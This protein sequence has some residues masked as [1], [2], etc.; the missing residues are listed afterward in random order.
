M[1]STLGFAVASSGKVFG[2][3]LAN[4]WV[5]GA[6]ASAFC[7]FGI[8]LFGAFDF[9]M[10]S[11]LQNKLATLG[12]KRSGVQKVFLMGLV[13]GIIAAPCTGPTLGAILTYVAA[14][15]NQ[16]FGILM[17]M[18]F[19]LGLGLPFL[20]LGTFAGLVAARPKPGPWMESVK[21]V[22]G[23]IMFDMALYF[24]RSVF[25][26][27]NGL[28]GSSPLYFIAGAACIAG[29]IAI[30][31]LNISFHRASTLRISRKIAGIVLMIGGSF[32]IAG[33]AFFGS[34]H[35]SANS[36]AARAGMHW[37]TDLDKGLSLAR[38]QKK[39]AIIDFYADWC[40]ACKE[41]DKTVFSN[42]EV[43]A[44]LSRFVCIREDLTIENAATKKI[45]L[46][47]TLRGIPVIE[48]YASSGERLA[49]NRIAGFVPADKLLTML[50]K[51]P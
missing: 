50:K 44:E 31:G 48:F 32:G 26:G 23:I 2:Q 28:F 36:E 35:G 51:I 9:Q 12:G 24:L 1:F 39:P 8:S 30:G 4:P 42:R 19:S 25:P 7:L 29:G 49:Q 15:G 5:I 16:A 3:F 34:T 43:A 6:I 20:I 46:Q 27:L 38:D 22:L 21:A 47:Y 41:L 45:A 37:E 14:A 18:S 10:P 13:A 11:F 33:S 17:L 40:I